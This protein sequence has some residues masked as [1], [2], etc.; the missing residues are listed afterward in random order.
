MFVNLKQ[1]KLRLGISPLVLDDDSDEQEILNFKNTNFI[2]EQ[3]ERQA[4][5]YIQGYTNRI[6]EFRSGIQHVF[7]EFRKPLVLNE[8]EVVEI[9]SFTI[10]GE[11]VASTNYYLDKKLGIIYPRNNYSARDE[12]G[13]IVTY[14]AGLD[15]AK[16]GSNRIPEQIQ[17]SCLDLIHLYAMEGND[18]ITASAF[19]IIRQGETTFNNTM[20][21]SSIKRELRY[22]KKANG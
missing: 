20:T 21:L 19:N 4:R 12:F 17:K 15:D 13:V 11:A 8:P 22:Y 2:L 9:E 6:W 5:S 1:M 3:L 18:D 16:S 7:N 14:S 10:K